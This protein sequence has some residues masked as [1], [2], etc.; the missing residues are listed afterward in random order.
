MQ[1]ALGNARAPYGRR[2]QLV[3]QIRIGLSKQGVPMQ[4]VLA[5]KLPKKVADLEAYWL[6]LYGELKEENLVR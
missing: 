6:K 5:T 3:M 4:E 1:H 2:Y